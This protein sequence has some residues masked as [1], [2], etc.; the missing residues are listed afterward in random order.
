MNCGNN[1]LLEKQFDIAKLRQ[2]QGTSRNDDVGADGRRVRNFSW[3]D[4]LLFSVEKNSK[5]LLVLRLVIPA[6]SLREGIRR[7]FHLF[8]AVR[9]SSC[10]SDTRQ[11]LWKGMLQNV[12]QLLDHTTDLKED[13]S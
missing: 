5:W 2:V 11:I 8:L 10:H 12:R 6:E 1:E 4:D 9:S 7:H 13:T 3:E